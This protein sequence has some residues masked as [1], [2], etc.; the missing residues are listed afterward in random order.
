MLDTSRER[1]F[2]RTHAQDYIIEADSNRLTLFALCFACWD[3]QACDFLSKV[4][5]LTIIIAVV[6]AD[7]K[8]ALSPSV[9]KQ[10]KSKEEL[11]LKPAFISLS[12]RTLKTQA[13]YWYFDLYSVDLCSLSQSMNNQPTDR[14]VWQLSR[15]HYFFV[16]ESR[17]HQRCL[18]VL[19]TSLVCLKKCPQMSKPYTKVSLVRILSLLELDTGLV[20]D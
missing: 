4:S 1:M 15:S 5:C 3:M 14:S 12:A 6:N 13:N 11:L 17:N 9:S 2:S 10:R 7:Q 18:T 16:T 8:H 20:M 19:Q